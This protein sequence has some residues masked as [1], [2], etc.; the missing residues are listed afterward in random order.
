[1]IPFEKPGGMIGAIKYT[2]PFELPRLR[3][4]TFR[5]SKQLIMQK[6]SNGLGRWKKEMSGIL[7]QTSEPRR[8]LNLVG[9]SESFLKKVKPEVVQN[10]SLVNGSLKEMFVFGSMASV[11][12]TC[13]GN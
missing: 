4:D 3:K 5:I 12:S 9:V 10:G 1:M 6:G 13:D 8:R 11:V 2:S 7:C